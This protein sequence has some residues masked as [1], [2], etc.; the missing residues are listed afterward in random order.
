MHPL[1]YP[2]G[3][4]TS[5]TETREGHLPDEEAGDYRPAHQDPRQAVAEEEVAEEAVEE[6]EGRFLHPDTHLPN[7]LRNF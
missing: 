4:S 7:L 6:E 1:K 5:P 3:S 2:D